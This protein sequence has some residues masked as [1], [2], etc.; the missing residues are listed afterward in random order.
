MQA[1]PVLESG[2]FKYY[3]LGARE[4]VL[5]CSS[6]QGSE[7]H[8]DIVSDWLKKLDLTQSHLKCGIQP[9]VTFQ[10]KKNL[11]SK[12]IEPSQINNNCSESIAVF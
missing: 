11:A 8:T 4:A 12:G 1:L 10:D 5:M 3:N 2:A 6:H 7:A 9:P